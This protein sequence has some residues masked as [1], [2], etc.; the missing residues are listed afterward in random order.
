MG[1]FPH[2]EKT[3]VVCPISADER[4]PLRTITGHGRFGLQDSIPG[5]TTLRVDVERLEEEPLDVSEIALI[6]R[7]L[8][9][10]LVADR[11]M[12]SVRDR[13][14]QRLLLHTPLV[15]RLRCTP[16]RKGPSEGSAGRMLGF[17]A[18]YQ[19]N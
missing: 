10:A 17:L 8:H 11:E 7:Y 15:P 13:R 5:V 9:V 3:Y 6:A 4:F 1:V 2:P 19:V 18:R 16:T 12:R 14:R